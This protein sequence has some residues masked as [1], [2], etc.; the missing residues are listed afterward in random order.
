LTLSENGDLLSSVIREARSMIGKRMAPKRVAVLYLSGR[1]GR[2]LARELRQANVE[3]YWVTDPQKPSNR[4]GIAQ[5][6]APVILST[7]HSAKGMEFP[8][9]ALSCTPRDDNQDLE[10]LRRTIYVGMT[11]ATEQL[12]VFAD[13]GH[14]LVED[15]QQASQTT[16]K[17]RV[18]PLDAREDAEN[19]PSRQTGTRKSRSRTIRR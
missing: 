8:G 15:L 14:P 16:G 18:D 13:S 9:V 6:T 5:A 11:R 2:S 7:V 10:E 1:E 4:D 17:L 19:D 3:F 12:A